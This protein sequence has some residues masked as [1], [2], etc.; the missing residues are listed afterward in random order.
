MIDTEFFQ[1]DARDV[2]TQEQ[3]HEVQGFLCLF[4]SAPAI[5]PVDS[6][7]AE[8]GAW[9]MTDHQIPSVIEHVADI[10]LIVLPRFVGRQEIATHRIVST[11]GERIA[12]GPGILAGD[13]HAQRENK[14]LHGTPWGV[15]AEIES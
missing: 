1:R 12:D 13:Q 14:T 8:V 6:R 3:P 9:R 11:G 2:G 5:V 4:P 7:D 10:A 15:C